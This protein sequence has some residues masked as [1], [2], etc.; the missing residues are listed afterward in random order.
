MGL[1]YLDTCLLIYAFES[2]SVFGQRVRKAMQGEPAGR[3]AIS[4][5][6]KFECL[7]APMKSGNTVL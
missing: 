5:L 1:I 6:V 2:D 3:F 7:V 4:L